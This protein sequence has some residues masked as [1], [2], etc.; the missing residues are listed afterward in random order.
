MVES[1]ALE[2]ILAHFKDESL[3]QSEIKEMIQVY[4]RAEERFR[5]TAKLPWSFP[6]INEDRRN[7]AISKVNE[8]YLSRREKVD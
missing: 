6:Q 7:Y 4:N 2:N 8:Y 3:T 1:K 5:L